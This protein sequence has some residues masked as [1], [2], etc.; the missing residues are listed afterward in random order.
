MMDFKMSVIPEY[1]HGGGGMKLE[2]NIKPISAMDY[3]HMKT[4]LSAYDLNS[5]KS[6]QHHTTFHEHNLS[7]PADK[8]DDMSGSLKHHP[9]HHLHPYHH[10]GLTSSSGPTHH[11]LFGV[12]DRSYSAD[13]Q[14]LKRLTATHGEQGGTDVT[15]LRP[16]N[17]IHDHVSKSFPDSSVNFGG[18]ASKYDGINGGS[19]LDGVMT[20]Q[21]DHDKDYGCPT[22]DSTA[23]PPLSA[24]MPSA[25]YSRLYNGETDGS[26]YF[27]PFKFFPQYASAPAAAADKDYEKLYMPHHQDHTTTLSHYKSQNLL[28]DAPSGNDTAVANAPKSYAYFDRSDPTLKNSDVVKNGS[29]NI[30]GSNH[31]NSNNN[32]HSMGSIKSKPENRDERILSKSHNSNSGA[33]L[34]QETVV[35]SSNKPSK[36][37]KSESDSFSKSSSTNSENSTKS[38]GSHNDTKPPTPNN[39]D[40]PESFKDPNVKPPYSYVALIAMAIKESAEKRLTLSGIYQFI[41]GRFPYY[42]KNKKG[43]QNSIRHNLSLNECFVKVAREGGGERKG[44]FWTLDPAF[45]DMFEKGNYRRRRRMKRPYRPTLSLHKP[46]FSDHTH[47]LNQF[48]FNN[49]FNTPSYSQYSGYSPWALTHNTGA[50]NM[51]VSQLPAYRSC[52]RMSAAN[53]ALNG[54]HHQYS[55]M[56]VGMG[57]GVGLGAAGTQV[58]PSMP[59]PSNYPSPYPQFSEYSAVGGGSTFGFQYRQQGEAFNSAHY[60]SYWADR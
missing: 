35:E 34:K 10:P 14:V 22:Q 12:K 23:S 47:A 6:H 25:L 2:D 49:Y 13:D 54:L 26:S 16:L 21:R 32:A 50:T 59:S 29:I 30:S 31:S 9:L 1:I 53:S 60:N 7:A 3:S 41:I 37:V 48:A 51:G 15:S 8:E 45:E 44:N 43:W 5:I 33:I 40:N 24:S 19:S 58:A 17:H 28:N 52:Q 55:T 57:M 27:S 46:L 56:G 4:T 42:E 11:D 18:V 20:S 38:P 36:I 39:K